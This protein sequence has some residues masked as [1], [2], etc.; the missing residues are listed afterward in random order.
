MILNKPAAGK[1]DFFIHST[2]PDLPDLVR[3]R[4][5]AQKRFLQALTENSFAAASAC[6][7]CI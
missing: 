2:L 7:G 5:E 3:E 1:D 6:D 4:E